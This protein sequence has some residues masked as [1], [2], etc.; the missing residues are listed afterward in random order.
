MQ[1]IN[2]KYLNISISKNTIK[3]TINRYNTCNSI[4][5]LIKIVAIFINCDNNFNVFVAKKFN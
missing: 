4:T 2:K 3:R 1:Q 5:R